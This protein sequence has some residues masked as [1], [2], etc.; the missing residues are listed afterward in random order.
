M[1]EERIKRT[2]REC[3]A[4]AVGGCSLGYKTEITK[5]R[6]NSVHE[7]KPL[8]LCPKPL[9]VVEFLVYWN[10]KFNNT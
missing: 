6:A 7:R 10:L 5:F 3:R 8:E 4:L 1:K 9:K 2:C